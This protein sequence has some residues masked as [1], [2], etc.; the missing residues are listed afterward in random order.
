M[1][2]TKIDVTNL[3]GVDERQ[4]QQ[5][6]FAD[7]ITNMRIDPFTGGWDSRIGYE[8]FLVKES[9]FD[10]WGSDNRIDSIY[11]WNKRGGALDQLV[12]ETGGSI[13]VCHDWQGP[14]ASSFTLLTSTT[15]VSTSTTAYYTEFGR[16]LIITTGDGQPL[17]YAGWPIPPAT[18]ATNIPKYNLGFPV[19]PHPPRPRQ[20]ETDPS[21]PRP[22]GGSE[23]SLFVRNNNTRGQGLGS[24]NAEDTNNFIYKVSFVSNTGSESPLSDE[25]RP[26]EWT[27]A[28][29][30]SPTF[31][32]IF[33]IAVEI[34]R[35]PRGTV[36]RRLYRTSNNESTFYLIDEV[37]NNV[38]EVYHDVRR[39]NTFGSLEPAPTASVE[40]PAINARFCATFQSCLFL[41]GGEA[42]DTRLYYSNPLKPDQFSALDFMELGNT[43]GGGIR[44]LIN[45][46]NFLVVLRERSIDV[47]IGTYSTGFKISPILQGIGSTA[48]N[49]AA[50]IPDLGVVFA[51]YNGVYL[52][53][54]NMEYSD[55]PK[56]QKISDPIKKKWKRVNKDQL[57][58][59]AGCYSSKYREYH[60]YVCTYGSS[61]PNLGLIFHPDS[62]TW[63]FREGFPVSCVDTDQQGNIL[64]GHNE[65]AAESPVQAGV[66]VI[67]GLRQTGSTFADD[68]LTPN[69]APTFTIKSP[70]L[71]FGDAQVKKKVR[72]VAVHLYTTGKG[73]T[74]QMKIRKDFTY[75]TD[76]MATHTAERPEYASQ[77]VYDVTL[78]DGTKTWEDNLITTVRWDVYDASC[79][80]FQW[81]LTGTDDVIIVGYEILF[82]ANQT[83][84][85][86]GKNP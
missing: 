65:G 20:P 37:K 25:S 2:G 67:S 57:T 22:T 61:I 76:D 53:S 19:R 74:L 62:M 9:A 16:W 60:L 84:M 55:T 41:D 49:S 82:T 28:G 54:G 51:T 79:S 24:K 70:W 45:Y 31:S 4:P 47:V 44:G 86:K 69:G 12:Y 32:Y 42:E 11:Y 3:G 35:G 78:L 14:Q 29:D 56:I 33:A 46:F 50:I 59:A 77:Q 52:L 66:Q 71:D 72:H 30:A 81:E 75:S 1:R 85:V 27:T 80:H 48:A 18:Q 17:K 64:F 13:K 15:P 23:N 36:A 39:F 34:P 8:K 83:K 40:F 5:K 26:A 58:R 38:D 68:T 7:S 73:A 6:Q 43:K 21:K 10:P 63:S